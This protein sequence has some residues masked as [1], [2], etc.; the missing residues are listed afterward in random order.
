MF[1][2]PSKLALASGTKHSTYEPMEGISNSCANSSKE[3]VFW[4]SPS[5]T[6]FAERLSMAALVF[7][8][9]VAS[10]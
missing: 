8:T 9:M 4:K 2:D 6:S 3:E 5:W 1:L 10:N 7:L